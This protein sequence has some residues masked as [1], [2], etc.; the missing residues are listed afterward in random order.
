MGKDGT[1]GSKVAKDEFGYSL[2]YFDGD[3]SAINAT[4]SDLQVNAD[5]NLY[6]GNIRNSTTSIRS[7]MQN[8]ASQTMAY[9]YDQLNRLAKADAYNLQ[10]GNLTAKNDYKASYS[11]DANGNLMTLNR[12][13][14]T[15][16]GDSLKKDELEYVYQTKDNGYD[17]NTNKLRQV[18]DAVAASDYEDVDNQGEDNYSYDEIGN[19]IKDQQ[20]G[21]ANISWTGYGKSRK[22]RKDRRQKYFFCLR[23]CRKQD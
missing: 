1:A 10:N 12:N 16:T 4:Q 9:Q 8:G 11:Y 23:C 7:L 22:C 21:F 2:S 15:T 3:Y 19:L 13:A 14:T 20:E 5:N 6:N 18:K 17:R